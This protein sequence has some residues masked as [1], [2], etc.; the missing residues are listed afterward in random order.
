MIWRGDATRLLRA[1]R[2]LGDRPLDVAN[3]AATRHQEGGSQDDDDD[4]E[5]GDETTAAGELCEAAKHGNSD[6]IELM[7]ACGIS[8]NSADYDKRTALHLACSVGNKAIC[9][10]L[11]GAHA[12]VNAK[13]RWK[14]T[15]L[16]DAIRE[17]HRD[18]ALWL[19]SRGSQ[20]KM[21]RSDMAAGTARGF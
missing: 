5:D 9:E 16:R 3:S 2:V 11:V 19:H 8:V 14:N 6:K 7:I 18:L 21:A 10:Q 17:G 12:N 4:D 1:L 13:D 20:L 15:P